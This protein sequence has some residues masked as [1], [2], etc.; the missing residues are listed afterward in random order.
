[1]PG[2][3]ARRHDLSA[4]SHAWSPAAGVRRRRL[5]RR[6]STKTAV[7]TVFETAVSDSADASRIPS[8]EA[9][10]ASCGTSASAVPAAIDIPAAIVMTTLRTLRRI[11]GEGQR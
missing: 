2:R 7:V 4:R 11:C 1:M 10:G 3:A 5:R 6:R 9:C 8:P